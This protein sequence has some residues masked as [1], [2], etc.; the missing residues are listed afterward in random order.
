MYLSIGVK[1]FKKTEPLLWLG[2]NF[3]LDIF[4]LEK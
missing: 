4:H 1:L 3:T 2:W